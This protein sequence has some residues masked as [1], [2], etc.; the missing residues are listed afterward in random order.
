MK[1]FKTN[2]KLDVNTSWKSYH[3]EIAGDTSNLNGVP[4]A[5]F[6]F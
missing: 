6:S 3:L 5:G 4:T 2:L 1:G